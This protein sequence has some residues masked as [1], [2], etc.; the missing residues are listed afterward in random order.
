MTEGGPLDTT[1]SVS[2]Y[3]YQQGFGFGNHGLRRRRSPTCCSWR[4]SCS[5]PSSS[6]AVLRSEA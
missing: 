2:M 4:S 1:L 5:S 3:I 6:S